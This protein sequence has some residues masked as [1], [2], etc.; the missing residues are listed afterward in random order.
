MPALY[1]LPAGDLDQRIVIEQRTVA[2]DATLGGESETWATLATVWAKVEQSSDQ[3][4]V[5]VAPSEA[6]ETYA[7]PTMVWIRWRSDIT[8]QDHRLRIGGKLLQIV[9]TAE[10]GRRQ[11]LELACMEWAHEN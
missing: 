5:N 7:R 2:R 4:G 9:G 10:L 1:I 6:S 8:R 3:S 11:A